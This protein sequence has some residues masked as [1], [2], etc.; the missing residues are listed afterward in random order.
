[1]SDQTPRNI[2]PILKSAWKRYADYDNTA[3]DQKERYY[4]LRRWVLVASVL[5]TILAVLLESFRDLFVPSVITT[6]QVLLILVPITGSVLIAF[7]SKFQQGYKYLAMRA[8]AEEILKEIYRYRTIMQDDPRR[9]QWLQGRLAQ[10]QRQVHRTLGGEMVVTPYKGD[11]LN[12]NYDPSHPETTDEGIAPLDSEAYLRLRL[13]DQLNWHIKKIQRHQRNRKYLTLTIL[14]FGGLGALFAGLDMIWAGIAVWVTL[15]TALAS[16]FTNWQ[17]LAGVDSIIPIYS[18]VILELNILDDYWKSLSPEEQTQTAFYELVRNTEEV[19]WSQHVL[20]ISAMKEAMD[21]A[22]ADQERMVDEAIIASQE[23]VGKVQAEILEEA[24]RSMEA[25]T[26]R[27]EEEAARRWVEYESERL[28]GDMMFN[29]AL[30]PASA[31]IAS[32]ESEDAPD[33]F[34]EDAD[35]ED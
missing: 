27:A 14:F 29:A 7:L 13:E 34:D 6:M 11:Q 23:V 21:K 22:E 10:I 2:P 12:P 1:M 17:E 18:K 30:G 9:D 4:N 3:Q 20:F 31:V 32:E 19:L 8:G 28:P 33:G 26:R 15:T 24:R 35:G 5:A 16:A 25:A